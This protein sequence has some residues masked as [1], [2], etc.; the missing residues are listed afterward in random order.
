[1]KLGQRYIGLH[2]P[3][4]G[5]FLLGVFLRWVSLP[6][7]GTMLHHDEA[8]NGIDA[9]SIA[10]NPRFTPF[11]FNNFGR[12]SGWAYWLIPYMLVF[13]A[14]PFGIRLAATTLGILTLVVIYR[15]GREFYG[16][17]GALWTMAAMA[18]F[19]WHVHFSYQALRAQLYVFLGTLTVALLLRAQ[20][21]NR[22]RVW[23]AGGACLGLLTYTYFASFGLIFYLGVLVTGIALLDRRRRKG[24]VLALV[25]AALLTLPMVFFF[26]R[27]TEQFVA[28]PATVSVIAHG[29]LKHNIQKWMAAWFH[30]GD[31]NPEFNTPG[32]PILGPITGLLFFLGII[33]LPFLPRKHGY[34]VFLIGW[35]VI[36]CLPSLISNLAPHFLRAAGMTSPI[37]LILGGGAWVLSKA[38]QR[39]ER[40]LIAFVMPGLLL[41]FVG[42]NTYTLFHQQWINEPVTFFLM[43][44]HINQGINY[45]RD[46]T[47]VERYVYFSPFTLAHP[48][49]MFRSPELIPRPIGAFNSH[50]CLVLPNQDAT[51]FSLT[52]YEPNFQQKLSQWAD[53]IPLHTDYGPQNSA[54]FT[55]FSARPKFYEHFQADFVLGD[56]L[57][58]SLIEPLPDAVTFDTTIPVTL[59]IRPLHVPEVGFGGYSIFVH[60]YGD[61]TPY[62]GGVLWGQ[63][64]S[65]VC[66]SYPAHLWQT[67]EIIVQEFQMALH[68]LQS[69]TYD[70]AIG[71]YPFPAGPRLPITQKN[72][73]LSQ[74]YIIIHTLTISE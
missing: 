45:I 22:L 68:N 27:H 6:A 30:E 2:W 44:Q 5:V 29:G 66:E 33:G 35:L 74:D 64:D 18:V 1:M 52:T 67:E 55:I 20:R 37:A 4:L 31:L 7:M 21:A 56:A 61:P 38:L 58:V 41:T 50:Q 23:I 57:E 32:K 60:L 17:E 34:S 70:I 69:G 53:I 40:P 39:L 8:W 10:K 9:L 36:T 26:L 63:A 49:I 48:V 25:I 59:G 11:L 73:R 51:Y 24:A 16:T 43:E 15:A 42:Y 3:V 72:Q 54:R 13:G 28:R 46:H 62:E 12:E 14:D 65:L 47:E 71:A 19:Y